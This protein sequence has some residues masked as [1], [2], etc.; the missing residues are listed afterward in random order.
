MDLASVDEFCDVLDH[1]ADFVSAFARAQNSL[2]V[3]GL[4]DDYLG[5]LD[6][7]D[8]L[9]PDSLRRFDSPNTRSELLS[10]FGSFCT[11]ETVFFFC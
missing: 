2:E 4:L 6:D 9:F 3:L 5:A 11:D 10:G 8:T 7:L 1:R